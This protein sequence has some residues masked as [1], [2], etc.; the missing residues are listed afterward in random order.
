MTVKGQKFIYIYIINAE[1]CLQGLGL[2]VGKPFG[3]QFSI[4]GVKD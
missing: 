2:G 3:D 4:A 1:K